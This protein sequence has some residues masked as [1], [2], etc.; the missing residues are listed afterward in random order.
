MGKYA[1]KSKTSTPMWVLPMLVFAV[2]II[3]SLLFL[4]DEVTQTKLRDCLIVEAGSELPAAEA[5]LLEESDTK[6]LYDSGLTRE[7]LATPG[8][9]RVALECNGRI[10]Y[11]TIC[12]VDTIAPTG[13]TQDLTAFS[14][15]LPAASEFVTQVQDATAVSITYLTKPDSNNPKPQEVTILLTDAGGN[16]TQLHAKLTVT[17]D[18]DAPVIKGVSNIVAYTGDA[19]AYRSGITLS[20]NVDPAP[21]LRVD[22]SKVDLSKAGTYPVVYTATDAAGNSTSITA[23]VTVYQ[24]QPSYVEIPVIY[25]AVDEILDDIITSGMSNRQKVEAIYRWITTHYGYVNHSEKDDWMQA[26]YRMMT[27]IQGDCFNY[28]ALCKLMLERLEIPNIDVVKIPNY[29]G[30]S[31]HYWSLVS[32]DGGKT[33]YHLDTTPRKGEGDDFCLV[34]DAF[35]DSYSAAHN[36]CFNRDK[37]L[38]PATPEE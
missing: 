16:V 1:R 24:K 28:Y 3:I 18:N 4:L 36:N 5:F 14:T 19:V 26:A 29:D 34:T 30:D 21:T 2:A 25:A 15:K 31:N 27:D 23:Q 20:D 17:I 11:G 7:Q 8:E 33:Y 6:I 13:S 22:S 12:V 10:R 37:T 32:V 38:Y 9:Y 35:I